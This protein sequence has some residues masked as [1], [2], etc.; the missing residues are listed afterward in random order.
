MSDAFELYDIAVEQAD[1]L[2]D[3]VVIT[4]VG[5]VWAFWQRQRD[6]P[7]YGTLAALLVAGHVER[8]APLLE[9]PR[10]IQ[11]AAQVR[12][13]REQSD[14]TRYEMLDA[15]VRRLVERHRGIPRDKVDGLVELGALSGLDRADVEARLRRHRLVDPAVP[16]P[17]SSAPV[18]VSDVRRR[19]IRDLLDEFGRLQET[20]PPPTLFTLLELEI[21]ASPPEVTHRADAF[22]ARCRE[23]PPT[24]LRAVADELAVHV[25][26]VLERGHVDEY[27]D[28]VALDVA[29]AL[30][31]RVRAAVLVE[32]RLVADDHEHL[33][34]EALALGLDQPRAKRVL[35][36]LAAELGVVAEPFTGGRPSG[37][38]R[39]AE[40]AWTEALRSARAALRSGRVLTARRLAADAARTGGPD[41]TTATRAVKDEVEAAIAAA[42]LR[43]RAATTALA[44]RR[45]AEAVEHLE[46]L[47]R[48]A[49]ELPGPPQLRSA[50][51]ELDRARREIADA[52]AAVATAQSAPDPVEALL[53]VLAR[54]PEHPAAVAALAAAPLLPPT[55]VRAERDRSGAVVVSWQ[56]SPT[57][58]VTYRVARLQPDGSTRVVGRTAARS[59]EDGGAGV[60]AVPD[61]LVVALRAGHASEQARTGAAATPPPAPSPPELAAPADLDRHAH[62]GGGGCRRL[63]RPA[64]RRVQGVATEPGRPLAGRGSHACGRTRGRGRAFRPTGTPLCRAGD[65]C[66]RRVRGDHQLGPTPG[67]HRSLSYLFLVFVLRNKGKIMSGTPVKWPYRT[68]D[69]STSPGFNLPV[70]RGVDVT[71]VSYSGHH[72]DNMKMDM[73]W[74]WDAS[75]VIAPC[76]GIVSQ[77]FAPGGIEIRCTKNGTFSGWFVVLLHMTDHVPAG[78]K[79][80]RG[81]WV[82]DPGSVGTGAKHLHME[83]GYHP[84]SDDY[85][86][87]EGQMVNPLFVEQG[88]GA[89]PL[90]LVPDHAVHLTSTNTGTAPVSQHFGPSLAGPSPHHGLEWPDLPAG[91]YYGD[92]EGPVE[93][94]GGFHV[95]DRPAI[96]ALQQQLIWLGCVPGIRDVHDTWA[97]GKYEA[98]TGDAVLL[99]R[100]KLKF[101]P[102]FSRDVGELF[103][104]SLMSR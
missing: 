71:I 75:D 55:Q 16:A 104:K 64:R 65:A 48:T 34:G 102:R 60:G 94:H 84:G 21:T 19:Q 33:Y 95:A 87:V 30:R 37:P 17:A 40:P 5:E 98:P 31:G 42:E 1:S 99:A 78:T 24:R 100:A 49:D 67:Y 66:R 96:K 12:A 54:W 101:Q 18:A 83:Q 72:P 20:V 77:A 62:A 44:A 6:H 97:D 81:D 70:K 27:L 39:S 82:G 35:A 73:Y 22:R 9:R 90:D 103:W 59:V 92:I 52:D 10:R 3:A 56:A 11:L 68:G 8:S 36:G 13:Q 91:H 57:A 2:P 69:L 51:D 76:D 43:W 93:A 79:L 53:G 32:D 28:A 38:P 63:A 80:K 4:Q 47:R 14:A 74:D 23:L 89:E 85:E 86:P 46:E 88:G 15:A 61:Y 45:F 58:G 7:K 25:H 26:D 50:A 41:A 29:D